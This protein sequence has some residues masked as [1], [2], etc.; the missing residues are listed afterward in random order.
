MEGVPQSM[1]LSTG[2]W[3]QLTRLLLILAAGAAAQGQTM[4][5][6]TLRPE[7]GRTF[8]LTAEGSPYLC[9]TTVNVMAGD[10]LRARPGATLRF[11]NGSGLI[12]SGTLIVEGK[13]DSLVRF[14]LAEGALSRWLGIQLRQVAGS[15]STRSILR[16]AHVNAA[17]SVL[18]MNKPPAGTDGISARVERCLFTNSNLGPV[19]YGPGRY[20]FQNCLFDEISTFALYSA[21]ARMDV[22]NNI[23][24]PHS[25]NTWAYG[26]MLFNPVAPVF[27]QVR[28]NCFYGGP[29]NEW[30]NFITTYS[31]NETEYTQHDPDSTHV[32]ADPLLDEFL[33]PLA[34][35]P[36]I[37]AGDPDYQDPDQTRSDIGP[38]YSLGAIAPCRI[39][40][41]PSPSQWVLGYSYLGQIEMEAYP[42][43]TWTLLEGPPG[44]Q[45]QQMNR[46]RLALIWPRQFQQTGQFTVRVHGVNQVE[47]QVHEDSLTAVLD[48][49]PNVP[50]RLVQVEPCPA[51]DCLG[52]PVVVVDHLTAGS[53]AQVRLRVVDDNAGRLGVLQSYRY[54]T[55]L[56]GV[57][58]PMVLG[59]SLWLNLQLDTAVVRLDVRFTDTFASDSLTLDIR[60]RYAL[61][62]GEVSGVIAESTGAVF[63][64]GPVHVPAGASLRIEEG[65]SL[66]SGDMP[67][68]GWVFDVAGSLS[69]EGSAEKP[70]IFRSLATHTRSSDRRPHFLRAQEGAVIEGIAHAQFEGYATALQL[71]HVGNTSPIPISDCR[72]VRTRTSVLSVDTPV[73]I[74]RCRF[75]RPADSL[76]LGSS[77]VYLAGGQGHRVQNNLF[78]NPVVGVT[79][80]DG[81][82]LI[83]N[84]S[85]QTVQI[86]SAGFPRWPQTTHLG[87]GR[88]QSLNSTL[89]VRNNLFQ[90]R[91]VHFGEYFT[92]AQRDIYLA[93]TPRALWLDAASTVRAEWNWFDC[94]NGWLRQADNSL[95]NVT[96][97]VAFNDS[98][99]LLSDLRAGQGSPRVDEGADFR[100]FADSP[101]VDAGDPSPQWLDAFDGS[102]AD[103]GWRG[104]PLATEAAYTPVEG[105]V[106]APQPGLAE[107]PQRFR[108]RPPYPNPFNPSTTLE[109]ELDR[110]GQLDLRVYDLLGREMTVLAR[111]RLEPGVYRLYLDAS[112][113]ASGTY[114]ARARFAGEEQTARLLL[115]K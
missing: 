100:L 36:L 31:S 109:L 4:L 14:D 19:C 56:N 99:R 40:T 89:D 48:F 1:M 6:D 2:A 42:P 55:W 110:A 25:V 7:E 67:L 79:V 21:G 17:N 45:L 11:A 63:L 22:I 20:W 83:A 80:V 5:P 65:S 108:L 58:Q 35:S 34:E 103:I 107:L 49:E 96:H 112:R 102:R 114:F 24:L 28:Y 39:L 10:T 111:A 43:A 64:V 95:V 78:I 53:I 91:S 113:W 98:T 47:D 90:W 77:A 9:E 106:H 92:N 54:N 16:Y 76:L 70:V 86:L 50:P 115:I 59:D 46:N 74:A 88:V 27:E 82:A 30:Q 105:F 85:F 37:D 13:R 73:E 60:P 61:L 75:E 81:E 18:N 3:R 93:S 69:V 29:A 84:N 12:V 97:W 62:S 8:W 26:V 94:R 104:G 72:F 38:F 33:V 71:E 68:D 44:L 57:P 32:L 15:D 23:F 87:F 66:V 101:L 41:L 52:Q 51:G